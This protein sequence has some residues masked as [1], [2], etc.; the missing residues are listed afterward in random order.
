MTQR[1]KERKVKI[2]Q[3]VILDMILY[4]VF[5]NYMADCYV[6]MCIIPMILRVVINRHFVNNFE[7]YRETT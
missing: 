3:C 4:Q 5:S 2:G 6:C 1:Q 7:E